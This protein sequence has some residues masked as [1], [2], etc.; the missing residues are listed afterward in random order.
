VGGQKFLSLVSEDPW[1]FELVRRGTPSKPGRR[2]SSPQLGKWGG[3][4]ISMSSFHVV[5]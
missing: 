4:E 3:L 1:L 5:T 2:S